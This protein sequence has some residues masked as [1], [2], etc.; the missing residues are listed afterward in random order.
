MP[1]ETKDEILARRKMGRPRVYDPEKI[2]EEMLEWVKHEDS[3]NFAG[4]CA[5]RGYLPTLIW[6]L[7]KESEEFSDAYVLVKMKLAERRE[8]HLNAEALNYGSWQR[9]Q[10]GYDPFLSKEEDHEKDK[11]AARAKG[12]AEQ[13]SVN[14]VTLLQKAKNGELSQ[15]VKGDE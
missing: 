10:K 3:I 14:F 4:F 5:D 15:K 2:M 13:Q 7:E 9:Y 11:D 6:R 8:R 12:I 1:G